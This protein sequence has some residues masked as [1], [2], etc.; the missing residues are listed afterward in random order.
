MSESV[1]ASI[2]EYKIIKL[3]GQGSFAAVHLCSRNDH[4]YAVK[5]VPK[6]NKQQLEFVKNG[7]KW[8]KSLNTYNHSSIVKYYD[9][10]ENDA[11]FGLV[12][13]FIQGREL[14]DYVLNNCVKFKESTMGIQLDHV[15]LIMK[16]ILT[17]TKFIHDHGVSHGDMKLENIMIID[18]N[19]SLIKLIDFGLATAVDDEPFRG[20]EPYLSPETAMGLKRTGRKCD[21]WAVGVIMFTLVF[22]RMPFE[23]D[24]NSPDPHRAM[25]RKIAIASKDLSEIEKEYQT[26]QLEQVLNVLLERNPESRTLENPVI[27][28][29]YNL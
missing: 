9:N 15:H 22:G 25:L 5:I 7:C 16:E 24:K 19:V 28:L 13:E 27:E 8:L 20:S 29:Q 14:Y 23:L 3:L 11:D 21:I 17:V 18:D 6:K 1:S 26:P 10:V 4:Q 12:M 2:G